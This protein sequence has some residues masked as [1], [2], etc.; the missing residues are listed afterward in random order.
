MEIFLQIWAIL[1]PL[2]AAVV[3][4][5]WSRRVQVQDR[6]YETEQRQIVRK[7]TLEDRALEFNRE[8]TESDL[9]ELRAAASDFLHLAGEFV[10][11]CMERCS[12]DVPADNSER[13]SSTRASLNRSA[14]HLVLIA[15][16]ELAEKTTNLHNCAADFLGLYL[17]ADADS[18]HSAV[19]EYSDIKLSFISAAKSILGTRV[20]A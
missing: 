4:A 9:K 2:L 15:P 1:G 11:S 7:N 20:E 13:C 19:A 14:H 18:L 16:A 12:S 10:D 5:L 17:R 8:R 3:S 6:T